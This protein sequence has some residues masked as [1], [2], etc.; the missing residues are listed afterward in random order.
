MSTLSPQLVGSDSPTNM[1][2][3]HSN[4]SDPY[5]SAP[6]DPEQAAFKSS[7]IRLTPEPTQQDLR[8]LS[9]SPLNHGG[10]ND[11]A[12]G[13]DTASFHTTGYTTSY[14][15]FLSPVDDLSSDLS[16]HASPKG[17]ITTTTGGVS[18]ELHPEFSGWRQDIVASH[19]LHAPLD[20]QS[21][22]M[23]VPNLAQ[24]HL[25]TPDRSNNP[26]PDSVQDNGG[27]Q[28]GPNATRHPAQMLTVVTTSLK[29]T[30]GVSPVSG[31]TRIRSPIVMVE[32][33]SR[34][35][36]PVRE[37]F[38][39]ARRP[40]QS[41]T[42]LSPG[43]GSEDGDV[44][45]TWH[46]STYSVPRADDGS[47]LRNGTTGHAGVDPAA[48]D[49]TYIL[50]P[51]EVESQRRLEE[52]KADIR[53]W[54]AS[55]SV[56][57]SEAGDDA[58]H[59][60]GRKIPVGNRRRARSAGDP[61]PQQDFF[62][63]QFATQQPELP[64]PGALLH[65]SS[66]DGLSDNESD[67]DASRSESPAASVNE[68]KWA[69]GDLASLPSNG[70][71]KLEDK[72]PAAH[73]FLATRPWQDPVH[74]PTPSSAQTQPPSSN[75]A[76]AEYQRRAR[77]LDELSRYATWGTRP[78]SEVDVNSIIGAGGSFAKMSISKDSSQR[79]TR[80]SSL[81]KF[82]ERK[83]SISGLKRPLSELTISQPN[84]QSPTHE[85]G[86]K[87]PPQRKDS[88]PPRKLSLGRSP[89]SPSLS[90]GGA[91]IA[92]A[93]QMAAIGGRDPLNAV[94][95]RS[96]S[97]P[98]TRLNRGRS[99]SEITRAPAPG[100]IDLMT[101]HGG[102][103]VPNIAYS[104]AITSNNR[105]IQP[106]ASRPQNDTR[107]DEDDDDDMADEKGLMM[108][109]PV[110]TRLPVP[111]MEGFKT[112]ISQLNP[113]LQPALI[114]RLANEQVR[115]YKKLVESKANHA[116]A[117][118]KN[119][120][121]AGKFC[122]SQGGEA[123]M[124]P[125]RTVANDPDGAYTQF[126]ITG[127]DGE[128]EEPPALGENAVTAAQFPQ[129]VPLPPVKRLPAEFECS[130]CFKV[131]KFQKPS[132][133][134][135]HVHEDVQPFTCTFPHCNEPK[136]FKRKADWVRHENERH[137]KL[138][139]W[140][141][142]VPDCHHTCYR[143]DNFVQHLVREHKM[144][145]PKTKKAKSKSGG[146]RSQQNALVSGTGEESLWDL[147]DKCHH[148]TTKGPMEEP[149][150]FCGN[151]C[152]SWKKLTVHLAKHMEQIAMPILA[153]V[154]E[155]ELSSSTDAGLA[156][157]AVS[158]P[159]GS[160]AKGV[161]AFAPALEGVRTESDMSIGFTQAPY[162]SSEVE[163]PESFG[164]P[165]H[166]TYPPAST[167][168]TLQGEYLSA[169]PESMIDSTM[170]SPYGSRGDIPGQLGVNPPQFMPV[171]QN[172]VTYPPP[173]NAG[174]RSR[175]SAQD[176]SVL[177][178]PYHFSA[179]PTEMHATYDPQGIVHMSPSSVEPDHTYQGR[180]GQA[181]SY[182][183]DPSVRYSHQF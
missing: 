141:C 126:Q 12:R 38:A 31:M 155:R 180:I 120:C 111:T 157:K 108:D 137:R 142:N 61:A 149:C 65:V 39:T 5:L 129:G 156:P 122:F 53:A 162:T 150:R 177:Q 161:A 84:N 6:I 18:M 86:I 99:R 79:H 59:P 164:A 143:K 22:A 119:K 85:E 9:T 33:Y 73:Q 127:H 131:K 138:E 183:Y 114:D 121:S 66:D 70:Q 90:T 173:F 144:P 43:G 67:T 88:F 37:T 50:S 75:A 2:F 76:I 20:E 110:L 136:S 93:G 112:Q 94:S 158:Y 166:P 139:W 54:S 56:A 87:N 167:S 95:P 140:T 8:E 146:A 51:N 40:S 100:L 89:K 71:H 10:N 55:V 153:L 58:P 163:R 28:S 74:D 91:V 92:I 23:D 174:P 147:V 179:S 81:R 102:P 30:L 165:L 182:S 25:L 152:S 132:D 151:V 160:V 47:W 96:T 35:D 16:A 109:F 168:T 57:N 176:L 115:R 4:F 130:I 125:P 11:S 52:K 32:S 72:E 46:T 101:S 29:D 45:G 77:E 113:R 106:V 36:S 107:D 123:A 154:Q 44:E 83:P 103:P 68:A 169:E 60:R 15:D 42:H 171:H 159:G 80:R 14:S 7:G 21:V 78:I 178:N 49:D 172:S 63:L 145:E 19:L 48:R 148:D 13:A 17:E 98:W 82:F 3:P 27:E 104:R 124:L 62:N 135:K 41:S 170:S 175:L 97:S 181:T 128:D 134:T 34:G 64:G 26:S 116:R 105:G 69:D 24:P 133:W 1:A 118:G 117:V